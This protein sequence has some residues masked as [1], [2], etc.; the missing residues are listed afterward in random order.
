MAS[1]RCELRSA[2]ILWDGVIDRSAY[3][4]NIRPLQSIDRLDLSSRV[5]F[6]VGENGSGKSTLLEA[7]AIVAGLNPEGGS[8]N[9]RFADRPTESVLHD[10]LRL[11]WRSRPAWAYFLRAETYFNTATAYER[12]ARE[13]RYNAALEELHLRSHGEQ[14]LNA[15][16]NVFRPHGFHVLDEPEAALSPY[17]QLQLMRHIHDAVG[18]GAQFV[19]ATHS[20]MLVTF[21]R[22]RIYEFGDEEIVPVVYEDALPYR[23]VRSF[24]ESPEEF[25]H[26]LLADDD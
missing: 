18:E 5:T 26:H 22:A 4:F 15:A 20:P 23:L 1:R 25:F 13:G 12:I 17:G 16:S 14:F 3:P 19:I 8:R 24:L 9:L 10:H 2:E 11:A 21:P 6:F 7:I